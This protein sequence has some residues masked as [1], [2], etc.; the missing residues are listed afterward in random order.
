MANR[1]FII[2]NGF[3]IEHG[4]KTSYKDFKE[5]IEANMDSYKTV[6]NY[7]VEYSQASRHDLNYINPGRQTNAA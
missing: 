5:F 4:L 1:L 3:D 6:E 7:S 2:G